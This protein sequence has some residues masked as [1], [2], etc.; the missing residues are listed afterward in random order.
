MS[1]SPKI[2]ADQIAQWA[3]GDGADS[4]LPELMRR[5]VYASGATVRSVWTPI[6]KNTNIGGYDMT[7]EVCQERDHIP[8]GASVWEMG[9]RQDVLKKLE[10]DYEERT[11]N[12]LGVDRAKTAYVAVTA[13]K[14]PASRKSD[15]ASSPQ[16]WAARKKQQGSPWREVRMI[17]AI[18]LEGW[19]AQAPAVAS[20]FAREHLGSATEGV[21]DAA[22]YLASYRP[23]QAQ[24]PWALGRLMC[25]GRARDIED[26]RRWAAGQPAEL[27]L[28]AADWE[29]VTLCVLGALLHHPWDKKAQIEGRALVITTPESWER[30]TVPGAAPQALLIAAFPEAGRVCRPTHAPI[31]TLI[32]GGSAPEDTGSRPLDEQPAEALAQEL[33][34]W[35]GLREHEAN[36]LVRG[37]G[38]S[39]MGVLRA[40]DAAVRPPAWLSSTDLHKLLP[41]LVVGQWSMERCGEALCDRD[42]EVFERFKQL[43]NLNTLLDTVIPHIFGPESP[44]EEVPRSHGALLRWRAREDAWR[45][46]H[47]HLKHVE[48]SWA[49]VVQ[50]VYSTPD[51]RFDL[52]A[53]RRILAP[54]LPKTERGFSTFLRVG[55]AHG[56]TRYARGGSREKSFVEALIASVLN[57]KDWRRWATLDEVL[58][59]LA[60]AAPQAFL[61]ALEATI[62]VPTNVHSRVEVVQSV[63]E[64]YAGH[65]VIQALSLVAWWPDSTQRAAL[66]LA[67]LAPQA[68]DA[69]SALEAIFNPWAPQTAMSD[70]QRVACL[71]QLATRWPELVWSMRIK[72]LRDPG[73]QIVLPRKRPAELEQVQIQASPEASK[74]LVAALLDQA[75][76]EAS[77]WRTLLTSAEAFWHL[78]QHEA[79]LETLRERAVILSQDDALMW[80]WRVALNDHYRFKALRAQEG[81]LHPAAQL[82][83]ELSKLYDEHEPSQ[84]L[85]RRWLFEHDRLHDP[86]GDLEDV[87][88]EH[89]RLQQRR[90]E[91]IDVMWRS[92]ELEEVVRTLH[93]AKVAQLVAFSLARVMDDDQIDRALELELPA[94]W[95]RTFWTT[96]FAQLASRDAPR[97]DPSAWHAQLRS[98]LDAQQE[99]RRQ[100]LIE[101]LLL[102]QPITAQTLASLDEL[103]S[104]ELRRVYWSLVPPRWSQDPDA[105]VVLRAYQACVDAGRVSEVVQELVRH[106]QRWGAWREQWRG[107]LS[108]LLRRVMDEAISGERATQPVDPWMLKQL[109]SFLLRDGDYEPSWLASWEIR[110]FDVL[111]SVDIF[112][113]EPL[114]L[115]RQLERDPKLFVEL[116]SCRTPSAAHEGDALD[117]HRIM[118][119][120]KILDAWRTRPGR[121]DLSLKRWV[122][123]ALSA[124]STAELSARLTHQIGAMLAY[125]GSA[126]DGAW[127]DE[128]VRNLLE[129]RADDQALLDGFCSRAYSRHQRGSHWLDGGQR[130]RSLEQQHRQ[131]AEALSLDW[132]VTA[133]QLRRVANSFASAARDEERQAAFE[134]ME[135]SFYLTSLR[136]GFFTKAQAE[137][138]GLHHVEDLVRRGTLEHIYDDVYR[139]KDIAPVLSDGRAE[140][141]IPVW[142][143]SGQ[144]GVFWQRTALNLHDLSD[145]SPAQIYIVL[146]QKLQSLGLSPPHGVIV[147]YKDEMPKACVWFHGLPI[148]NVHQTLLDCAELSLDLEDLERAIA[149]AAQGGWITKDQATTLRA[150]LAL[151][152]QE[153]S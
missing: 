66:A 132:P 40:L 125:C 121:G 93:G 114:E 145:D 17:D 88:E 14:F 153:A 130:E 140:A 36:D 30:Y 70:A 45:Y 142:L 19:L 127:P 122:E 115:F 107:E 49:E 80:T 31:H 94:D 21:I 139:L 52:P 44:L 56:L 51:A 82:W 102:S 118:L 73:E 28:R 96:L 87:S 57:T 89:R 146:P 128:E 113:T 136:E 3:K 129:E 10:E 108:R 50:L 46:L 38:R 74:Q 143:W 62:L 72:W 79:F 152:L 53:D 147:E 78:G 106:R 33:V 83:R 97:V 26:V 76:T 1:I 141:L 100:M 35:F 103:G 4:I 75:G 120:Y 39:V 71:E 20:W 151:K 99:D 16:D 133:A 105:Q 60:E 15:G 22:H 58:P 18:A 149:K 48:S 150:Q 24:A 68:K 2:T 116:W 59:S 6:G 148:T 77:R 65:G 41:A 98:R 137:L 104:E 5:L 134:R 138:A 7:L 27:R 86:G 69:A 29:E 34:R 63:G 23:R 131:W 112:D 13:H 12:P 11:K 32:P 42:H 55:L 117:E 123:Q 67:R 92:G 119:A 47:G 126:A 109:H 8:A 124:A 84:E 81:R 91:A 111:R 61:D 85:Q 95:G 37:A 43:G 135:R 64:H 54:L 110:A 90:D 101:S 25:A 144:E 9:V